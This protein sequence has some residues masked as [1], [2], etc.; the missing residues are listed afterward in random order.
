MCMSLVFW[1]CDPA[2]ELHSIAH[3]VDRGPY[4]FS[5]SFQDMELF[6]VHLYRYAQWK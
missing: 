5:C 4:N 3:R 2:T 6:S 1:F